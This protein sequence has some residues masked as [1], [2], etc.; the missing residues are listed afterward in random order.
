MTV[1]IHCK[2]DWL[3]GTFAFEQEGNFM[4]CSEY[5]AEAPD[6]DVFTNDISDELTEV[7]AEGLALLDSSKKNAGE[8]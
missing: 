4:I 8:D 6:V 1:S 2:D 3:E 7:I 5:G